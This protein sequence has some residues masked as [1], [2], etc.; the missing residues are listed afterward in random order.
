MSGDHVVALVA[1]AAM[2]LLVVPRLF[3]RGLPTQRL[4]KLALVWAVIFIAVTALVLLL[5]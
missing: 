5:G 4:I 3:Q 2:L 1:I